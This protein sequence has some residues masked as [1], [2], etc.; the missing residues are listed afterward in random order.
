MYIEEDEHSPRHVKASQRKTP[1]KSKH[2]HDYEDIA[3]RC[4]SSDKFNNPNDDRY[5]DVIAERC[6]I[7]GKIRGIRLLWKRGDEDLRKYRDSL[8]YYETEADIHDVKYV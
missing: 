7:C 3:L 4:K 8:P 1:K 6:T 5:W 2:K